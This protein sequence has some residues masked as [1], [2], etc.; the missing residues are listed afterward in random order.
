MSFFL[1]ALLALIPT[2]AFAQQFT[3]R[4]SDGVILTLAVGRF[5]VLR[6]EGG[7]IVVSGVMNTEGN[8]TPRLNIEKGDRV[9]GFQSDVNPSLERIATTWTALPAGAEVLLTLARGTAAPHQV[10]FTRPSPAQ[11]DTPMTVTFDGRPDA[12]AWVSAG[13]PGKATEVSIAGATIRNNRE[14]MPEVV[15]RGS[16]PASSTVP[17]RIGDVITAV[18]GRS[19]A[20]LAGLEK[21]YQPLKPGDEVTLALTRDGQ[22]KSITFRKPSE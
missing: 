11:G 18:N 12:G 3:A 15:N 21:F 5:A 13:S 20:A 7:S 19:I 1:L 2:S 4:I 10:R 17:L 16:H 9:V 22:P 8:N 6:S 14:G